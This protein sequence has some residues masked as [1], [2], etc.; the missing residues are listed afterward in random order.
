MMMKL[1]KYTKYC[2]KIL[3]SPEG[4]DCEILHETLYLS[5]IQTLVQRKD[6]G[7]L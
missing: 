7:T 5:K 6:P 1:L 4:I 2:P 3:F